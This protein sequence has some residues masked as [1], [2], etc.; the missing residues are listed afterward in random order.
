MSD[1]DILKKITEA[2]RGLL[3]ESFIECLVMGNVAE[4]EALKMADTL[5]DEL[6]VQ[7]NIKET[8]PWGGY[9]P[10]KDEP[11]VHLLRPHT[12]PDDVNNGFTVFL[13]IDEN[14]PH[15]NAY[16]SV[17]SQLIS[18]KFFDQLRTKQ[19]FG[20]I[21]SAHLNPINGRLIGLEQSNG[22]SAS[23]PQQ[24]T[25]VGDGDGLGLQ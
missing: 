14:K 15:I 9:I 18:Q 10:S 12:N 1:D 13:Y 25:A 22:Q 21:V 5:A 2:G 3:A 24:L 19:Q 11:E 16:G 6:G 7:G 17:L 8:A 4:S 20:Y 23:V